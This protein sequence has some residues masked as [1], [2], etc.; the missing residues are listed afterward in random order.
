M[1]AFKQDIRSAVYALVSGAATLG[2]L[3][4]AYWPMREEVADAGDRWGSVVECPTDLVAAFAANTSYIVTGWAGFLLG[5]GGLVG[6][7][8]AAKYHRPLAIYTGLA[9]LL[10]LLIGWAMGTVGQPRAYVFLLLPLALLCAHGAATYLSSLRHLA[11]VAA[12]ILAPQAWIDFQR[13][14]VPSDRSLRETAA[15]LAAEIK[16]GDV[17]ATP[18]IMGIELGHYANNSLF[19]GLQGALG[20]AGLRRLLFVTH[21]TDARFGLDNFQFRRTM[22]LDRDNYLESLRLPRAAF[23]LLHQTS[24]LAVYHLDRVPQ[25]VLRPSDWRIEH[26]YAEPT[27]IYLRPEPDLLEGAAGF[28][29]ENPTAA[30]FALHAPSTFLAPADGVALLVY[31]RSERARTSASLYQDGGKDW[32]PLQML[33]THAPMLVKRQ[34]STWYFDAHI[35]PVEKGKRYGIYVLSWD[36]RE[37]YMAGFACYFIRY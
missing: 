26:L 23:T 34:D 30:R 29:V 14:A 7:Y 12:V 24:R 27:P 18:Y 32:L 1:C 3:I 25:L 11:I 13:F 9:W 8:A 28:K 15:F 10:P 16:S 20:N 4:F 31:I 37:Q 22:L 2:A 21:V 33:R 6:L 36:T 17:V 5:L 19:R 35:I